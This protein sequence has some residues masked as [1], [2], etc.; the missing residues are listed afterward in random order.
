[1]AR[2]ESQQK[3][4]FFSEAMDSRDIFT[5]PLKGNHGLYILSISLTWPKTRQGSNVAKDITQQLLDR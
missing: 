3:G 1:M 4:T 2:T 5:M